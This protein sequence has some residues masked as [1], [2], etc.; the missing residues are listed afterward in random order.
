MA[1]TK[2]YHFPLTD[3]DQTKFKEWREL[4][5][6]SSNSI[7]SM[8]DTILAGKAQKSIKINTT[9]LASEWSD[10]APYEQTILVDGIDEN[11]NGII[12]VREDITMKQF[13]LVCD[14]ILRIGNQSENSLT[15]TANGIK[16]DF[17]IPVVIML[18]E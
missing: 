13:E 1:E 17:D 3:D 7:V 18:T 15:I 5:N 8:I 10:K 14:A 6:G 12:S 4:I 9:L 11:T 16:P 2:N